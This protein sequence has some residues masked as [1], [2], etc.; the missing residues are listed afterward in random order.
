MKRM[1]WFTDVFRLPA[2][3]VGVGVGAGPPPRPAH[4]EIKRE[5]DNTQQLPATRESNMETPGPP[6]FPR[7]KLKAYYEPCD[8]CCWKQV[9]QSGRIRT[10]P[11]EKD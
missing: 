2:T 8:S 5:R 7:R 4:A 1:M 11:S 6:A 10:F 3:G 9:A